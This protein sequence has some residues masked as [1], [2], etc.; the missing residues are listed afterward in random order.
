MLRRYGAFLSKK[1]PAAEFSIECRKG[2]N[3]PF[4]PSFRFYGRKV[5][6]KRGDFFCRFDT[7]IRKGHAVVGPNAQ[8]FDSFL[9][10]LYSWLL[11]KNNGFLIH[12]CGIKRGG[13]GFL[14]FGKSGAGKSTIAGLSAKKGIVLS[15]E[16]IPVRISGNSAY[17]YGSPF[18]GEMAPRGRNIRAPLAGIFSIRKNVKDAVSVLSGNE[19]LRRILKTVLFFS[20]ERKD[21]SMLVE[22]VID[23]IKLVPCRGLRFSLGGGLWQAI[24]EKYG[25]KEIQKN[26][27]QNN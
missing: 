23:L 19:P 5:E 3:R 14:F 11:A 7:L 10:T 4:K 16:L 6:I 27:A 17:I 13:A 24:E 1:R 20:H 18:W 22:L 2:K 25:S 21:C 8:S 26:C 9:R 15:D 12:A